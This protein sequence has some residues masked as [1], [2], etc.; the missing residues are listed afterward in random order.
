MSQAVVRSPAEEFGEPLLRATGPTELLLAG[1][2]GCCS[3]TWP[4]AGLQKGEC[5]STAGGTTR[6]GAR[7]PAGRFTSVRRFMSMRCSGGSGKGAR[8][9]LREGSALRVMPVSGSDPPGLRGKVGALVGQCLMAG[10]AHPRVGWDTTPCRAGRPAWAA[11]HQL[12]CKGRPCRRRTCTCS[13]SCCIGCRQQRLPLDAP[14]AECR[15]QACH[16]GFHSN[17]GSADGGGRKRPYMMLYNIQW[18][19]HEQTWAG[20]GEG[21]SFTA[22]ATRQSSAD[23]HCITARSMGEYE[24]VQSQGTR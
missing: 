4:C 13:A 24:G 6:S 7:A 11:W 3:S 5:S 18:Q 16:R 2:A 23:R 21:A 19:L 9:A 10:T 22:A 14:A 20:G 8:F 1:L 17:Q 12:I 15:W